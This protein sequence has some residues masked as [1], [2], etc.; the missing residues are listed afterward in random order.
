MRRRSSAETAGESVPARISAA[1]NTTKI[2]HSRNKSQM[3][4]TISAAQIM[5]RGE[6]S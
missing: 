4:P 6:S 3:A 5:L 2:G 1:T